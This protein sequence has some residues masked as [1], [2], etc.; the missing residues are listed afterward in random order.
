M[1]KE[2]ETLS[3]RLFIEYV[4]IATALLYVSSRAFP[5]EI[6]NKIKKESEG[7]CSQC[8][9]EVGVQNLI[10]SHYIHGKNSRSNG[11]ALCKKCE[12]EYHLSHADSPQIIGLNKK[13]NDPVVYGHVLQLPP[14][15][16]V[17][18]I[19]RHPTQWENVL[20]RLDRDHVF[21]GR[22]DE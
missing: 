20:N 6:R 11:R 4:L 3:I 22:D 5:K 10:A 21:S 7:V 2:H 17:E 16:Q 15:D 19:N 9:K 13:Q 12:T 18:L 8:S 1:K 14:S